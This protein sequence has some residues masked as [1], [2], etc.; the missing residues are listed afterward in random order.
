MML[1]GMVNIA[2]FAAFWPRVVD[3]L[4]PKAEFKGLCGAQPLDIARYG[5][6]K[7]QDV[8]RGMAKTARRGNMR[9]NI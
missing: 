3:N 1:T 2:I 6:Q 4:C 8:A 7:R 9:G 5:W